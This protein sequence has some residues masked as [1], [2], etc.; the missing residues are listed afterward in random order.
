M[1]YAAPLLILAASLALVWF[2]CIRPMRNR[3]G[4][5]CPPAPDRSAEIEA[6][7]REIAELRRSSE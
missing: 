3:P 2:C 1:T 5:C 4:G 6:L 7:R